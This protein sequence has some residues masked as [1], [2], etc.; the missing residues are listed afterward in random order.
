MG[1]SLGRPT[2]LSRE[3]KPSSSP[4]LP[5]AKSTSMSGWSWM[6]LSS[7]KASEAVL[8]HQVPVLQSEPQLLVLMRAPMAWSGDR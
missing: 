3:L 2:W 7:S 1:G 6:K 5:A 4:S 8:A